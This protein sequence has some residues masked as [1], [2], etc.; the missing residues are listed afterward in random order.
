MGG[1]A[2]L[3][4]VMAFSVMFSVTHFNSN[5]TTSR[6]VEN[7]S[8]YYTN[9]NVHNIA[10]SAM[11]M[12][13][14]EIYEDPSWRGYTNNNKFY[15]QGGYAIIDV[16]QISL[17]M[18][19]LKSTGYFDYYYD[20]KIRT[21]ES[22]VKVL[23][24]TSKFSKYAYYS[25]VEGNIWWTDKDTV[26]GPFHTQDN[27]QVYNHPVFNGKVTLK[28]KVKYYS[29]VKKD[30][31]NFLGGY[32]Q[33]IDLPRPT[34]VLSDLKATASSGGY[35][36]NESNV[37]LTF[38]GDSLSYKFSFWGA[39]N[40]VLTS[41][42][43]PNGVIYADNGNIRMKGTVKGQ[44][45]VVSEKQVYLDDDIVYQNDPRTNP[46]STDILG[47]IAK[48]EILATDNTANRSDINIHATMYSID[49]GFG[50]E[51]YSTR[52]FSGNI[53]LLGG[54]IQEQRQAVGTF[55]SWGTQ[56]GFNKRYKYDTR[57]M[58]MA[59]PAYPGTGKFEIVSWFE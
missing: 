13:A 7:L 47:I 55:S 31:P 49:E 26:W 38:K 6:A 53:N 4:V 56:R 48:K 9:A 33:G 12:A 37:Y 16:Q 5:K 11:N 58:K 36:F 34:T 17:D 51:N 50:A 57:L 14:N 28:N 2:I 44:F 25:N 15:I 32:E 21:K 24:R 8:D 23:L 10:T 3:L 30:K 19:E 41:D 43:A 29:S 52:P 42:L 59:P 35:I 22:L 40:T 45:T 27:M 54:M 1:K 39:E 18:I 20:G 46:S